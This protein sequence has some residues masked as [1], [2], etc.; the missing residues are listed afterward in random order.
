MK[1]LARLLLALSMV[2]V[3][4][5]PVLAGLAVDFSS[6]NIDF[7]NEYRWSLGFEFQTNNNAVLVKALG[8]YDDLKNGLTENH[9]VGIY[10]AGG[11]LLVS[12]VVTN[13]DPL[14][15]FFRMVNI[16]PFVLAANSTFRIAAVTGSENY[17]WNPNGFITD[18]GITYLE[19][20]YTE[21]NVL[22]FP[23][24]SAAYTGW[25]GPNFSVDYVVPLPSILVFLGTGL[26]G[27]GGLARR[28]F[29]LRGLRGSHF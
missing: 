10:D 5:S 25:F 4:A 9:A 7:N 21:S 19:N 28:R 17:T 29:G 23:V 26:V 1:Q 6:S 18:P 11:N 2:A 24:S 27:L 22:A 15:N 14:V 12:T 20:V 16:S 8:F 3:L 13:S